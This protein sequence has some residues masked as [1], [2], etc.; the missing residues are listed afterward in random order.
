MMT[1]DL[2]HY[3]RICGAAFVTRDVD[4]WMCRDCRRNT[5]QRNPSSD[6]ASGAYKRG[7]STV[8]QSVGHMGKIG[9]MMS[10][11]VMFSDMGKS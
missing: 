7:R 2:I 9:A 6:P 1:F 11:F 3:C 4:E 10:C 8:S 5:G